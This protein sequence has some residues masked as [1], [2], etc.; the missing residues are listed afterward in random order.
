MSNACKVEYLFESMNRELLV[1]H[2]GAATQFTCF[3]SMR[4]YLFES[5]ELLV[6]HAVL[7]IREQLLQKVSLP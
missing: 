4:E 7:V 5:R 1:V 3:T 6:V 2:A